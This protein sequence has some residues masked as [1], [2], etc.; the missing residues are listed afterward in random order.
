[1]SDLRVMRCH[2]CDALAVEDE[3]RGEV[4]VEGYVCSGCVREV[5]EALVAELVSRGTLVGGGGG[6]A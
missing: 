4:G 5:N 6:E 1:M 2:L 3:Y